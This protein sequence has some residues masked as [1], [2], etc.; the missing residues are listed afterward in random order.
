[1]IQWLSQTYLGLK[2]FLAIALHFLNLLHV[3]HLCLWN[4]QAPEKIFKKYQENDNS[5]V[6]HINI[7]IRRDVY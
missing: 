2:G 6:T 5:T 7:L 3:Q 4:W 1:M